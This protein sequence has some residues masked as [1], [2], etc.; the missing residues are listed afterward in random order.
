MAVEMEEKGVIKKDLDSQ[1]FMPTS[2]LHYD[3]WRIEELKMTLRF[4]A[5]TTGQKEALYLRSEIVEEWQIW[6][7]ICIVFEECK[8]VDVYGPTSW[9]YLMGN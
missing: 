2:M 3:N 7:R 5:Q 1:E 6:G 8:L 4:L 9:T